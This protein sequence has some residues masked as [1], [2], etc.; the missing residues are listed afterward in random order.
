[1]VA[2]PYRT[3]SPETGRRAPPR[4]GARRARGPPE[5]PDPGVGRVH[6]Q[7][8]RRR[9]DRCRSQ[10][11]A[12]ERGA[13][14]LGLLLR[15]GVEPFIGWTFRPDEALLPAEAFDGDGE[16]EAPPSVIVLGH[17]LWRSRFGGAP[18]VLGRT[19]RLNGSPLTV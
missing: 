8:L 6:Q 11:P 2:T 18:E 16:L 4:S 12:P 3:P 14:Y 7:R 19:V 13:R 1:V 17:G 10:S 5:Q 9:H 15:P